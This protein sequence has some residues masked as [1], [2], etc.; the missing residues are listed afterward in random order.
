MDRGRDQL[1]EVA[2]VLREEIAKL[3]D[4]DLEVRMDEPLNSRARGWAR[5]STVRELRFL[6]SHTVHHFALISLIL[7]RRGIEVDP[8]FGLAP[9]TAHFTERDVDLR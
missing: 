2:R 6:A 3:A 1:A 8:A 7:G 5:S 4:R 9:A